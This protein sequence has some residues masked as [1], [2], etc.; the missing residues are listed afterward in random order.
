MST[1]SAMAMQSKK[2]LTASGVN[3]PDGSSK[4]TNIN[5][6]LYYNNNQKRFGFRSPVGKNKTKEYRKGTV[7][8]TS[9]VC[10]LLLS[11]DN[12]G[13]NPREE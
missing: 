11:F 13:Q 12:Y 10:L 5:H 2:H 1:V 6:I 8:N 4:V 3:G 7:Y 9:S